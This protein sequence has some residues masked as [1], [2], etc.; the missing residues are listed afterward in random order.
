MLNPA[1]FGLHTVSSFPPSRTVRR[2]DQNSGLCRPDTHA[3]SPSCRTWG[4]V[5]FI[6][7]VLILFCSLTVPFVA[8]AGEKQ[9]KVKPRVK[10]YQSKDTGWNVCRDMVKNLNKLQPSQA[11]FL[12][13]LRFHPDMP[14]FSEPEWEELKIEDNWQ[15]IYD[16]SNYGVKTS[17]RPPFA[18]WQAQYLRDMQNG[19]A[20]GKILSSGVSYRL[21]FRP[22]L[23]RA[24]VRFEQNGPL[25]TVVSYTGLSLAEQEN[26]CENLYTTCPY[27]QLKLMNADYC[28]NY[29]KCISSVAKNH[30]YDNF[31]RTF[32]MSCVRPPGLVDDIIYLYVPESELYPGSNSYYKPLEN[33]PDNRWFFSQCGR[34]LFLYKGLAFS[35]SEN[36]T[37]CRAKKREDTA[38]DN[39]M[40]SDICT[41]MKDGLYEP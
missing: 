13:R 27:D 6:L 1:F 22:S 31:W 41:I 28:N 9:A 30:G 8:Q 26:F 25:V 24:K 5:F 23:R 37:I 20:E 34:Q 18:E 33:I 14:Q 19:Y 29:E 39:Y 32:G 36:H 15:I 35:I 3:T 17:D 21:P 38:I 16:L 40:F 12:C 10:Y 4:R 2:T 7:L 11:S